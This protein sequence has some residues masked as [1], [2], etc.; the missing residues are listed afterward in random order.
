MPCPPPSYLATKRGTLREESSFR[1]AQID[2][3][4]A[5][6][7]EAATSDRDEDGNPLS[8]RALAT[9]FDRSQRGIQA[10]LKRNGIK[11]SDISKRQA[12][13]PRVRNPG[14]SVLSVNVPLDVTESLDTSDFMRVLERRGSLVGSFEDL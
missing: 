10:V 13:K 1:G 5:R 14:R 12:T 6:I 9:R 11:I 7:I 4:E 8:L 3:A 2:R